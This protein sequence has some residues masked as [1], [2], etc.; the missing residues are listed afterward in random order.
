[1]LRLRVLSA[2]GDKV[3]LN[4]PFALVKVLTQAGTDIDIG[5]NPAFS[6]IDFNQLLKLV[7]RGVLGKIMEVESA[8]GDIVEIWV[9]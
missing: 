2:E 8:D 1:M 9:E 5:G 4:F 7:E 3:N 6:E